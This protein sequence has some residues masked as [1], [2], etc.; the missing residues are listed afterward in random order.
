MVKHILDYEYNNKA[1]LITF[2]LVN[3][4]FNLKYTSHD[5]W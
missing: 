3:I 2:V 5:N 1:E 4:G